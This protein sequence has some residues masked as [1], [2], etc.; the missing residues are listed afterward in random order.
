MHAASGKKDPD[1]VAHRSCGKFRLRGRFKMGHAPHAERERLRQKSKRVELINVRGAG[2]AKRARCLE[3]FLA[4]LRSPRA[5]LTECITLHS[6]ETR[7]DCGEHRDALFRPSLVVSRNRVCTKKCRDNRCKS[8]LR[9]IRDHR[10]RVEHLEFRSF[11]QSVSTLHFNRAGSLGTHA[12]K[13]LRERCRECFSRTF[14]H[15]THRRH[16]AAA[17]CENVEVLATSESHRV[18]VV[19]IAR[20][21]RVGVAIDKRWHHDFAKC[22]DSARTCGCA[23]AIT[24][25][26]FSNGNDAVAF[27]RDPPTRND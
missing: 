9:S 17:C 15:R 16:D 26:A 19:A 10:Y 12:L 8:S 24:R 20:P 23:R 22:I 4:L 25:F 5:S 7:N 2:H 3:K 14:A 21:T 18:F 13:M 1:G 6:A 11:G 27:T